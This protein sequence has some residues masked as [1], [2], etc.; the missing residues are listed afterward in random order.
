MRAKVYPDECTQYCGLLAYCFASAELEP[1]NRVNALS[2]NLYSIFRQGEVH[3]HGTFH[4]SVN[5]PIC[6]PQDLPQIREGEWTLVL[7]RSPPEDRRRGSEEAEDRGKMEYAFVTLKSTCSCDVDTGEGQGREDEGLDRIVVAD[8]I[9]FLESFSA[10]DE[11]DKPKMLAAWENR[12]ESDPNPITRCETN[13]DVESLFRLA[14]W[15]PLPPSKTT[16][17]GG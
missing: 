11:D 13:D 6:A 4:E 9:Q 5:N 14:G 3:G 16:C 10:D 2:A 17:I 7:I 12:Q 15:L 8:V 1:T